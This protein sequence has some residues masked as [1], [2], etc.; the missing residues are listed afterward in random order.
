MFRNKDDIPKTKIT[1]NALIA[2]AGMGDLL[3]S[4]PALNYIQTNCPWVNLLIW[5]P[6]YLVSFFKHVLPSKS[7][8]RGFTEAAKKYDNTKYGVSTKWEISGVKRQFTPMKTHP[9]QYSYQVLADYQPTIEE[10][11]YLKIKPD[12]IDISQFNLPE[13][14]VILPAASTERVKTIPKETIDQLSNYVISKGYTPV[15]LGKTENETGLEDMTYK[16]DAQDYDFSKGINLLNQTNILESAAIVSKAKLFLGIDSGLAHLAGFTDT[17]LVIYYSF[18]KA[19]KMMPIRDGIF[20]QNIYPIETSLGCG[21]C[22]SKWVHLE[23]DFRSCFYQ[24]YKCVSK[25][26]CSAEK[27]ISKIEEFNLL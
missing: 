10:M 2:E 14:F 25:E 12:E 4:L 5:C 22:Q 27:F 3:C 6:D 16:A 24:D 19:S 11:S 9:V 23:H 21:G 7:I 18:V 17:P 13:K 1:I 15:Y 26:E 20:G 8:I